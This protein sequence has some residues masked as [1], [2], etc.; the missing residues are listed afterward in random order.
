MNEKSYKKRLELQQDII[1]RQSKQIEDLKLQV[2][3]LKLEIKEKDEIINS[4]DHLREELIKNVAEIK[5]YKDEYAK[6]I[7]E[8]RRMKEII[9]HEA[10]K[11]KWWI[12]KHLLK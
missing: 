8:L 1:S 9:N 12:I 11:D 5:K 10:Y 6:L 3:S 4:V 2:E 7:G